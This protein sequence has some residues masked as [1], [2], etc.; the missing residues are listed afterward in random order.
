MKRRGINGENFGE[1]RHGSLFSG[2]GGFDLAAEWMGWENVFHCENNEFCKKILKYH[3]PNAK[4]YGDIKTADFSEW[5]GKVDVVS[6]GFPCQRFSVAGNQVGDE[7][8]IREMLRAIGEI[9][10]CSVVAENV[11]N[12]LNKK[13]KYYL[14]LFIS[15]LENQGYETPVIFDCSADAFGL[16]TLERHVWFITQANGKRQER[17][18][19]EEIQEKR[20][21]KGEFSGGHQREYDRWKLPDSRVCELGKGVSEGLDIETI[22]KTKWHGESIQAIGNGINPQVAYE[23]FKS[24]EQMN[25]IVNYS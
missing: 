10:P 18:P 11:G 6:G 21:R 1:M 14:N 5:R 23:I 12:I 19:K 15:G 2:I 13:F 24:I 22:S 9:K 4:S 7:T 8:F 16:P 3:W 25:R 20:T 17:S